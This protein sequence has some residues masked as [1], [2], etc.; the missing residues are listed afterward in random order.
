VRKKDVAQHCR[1][2]LSGDDGTRS[3]SMQ[4]KTDDYLQRIDDADCID[5][6]TVFV[7]KLT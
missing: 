2:N 4:Y 3:W 1:L 7:I 6:K 5:D